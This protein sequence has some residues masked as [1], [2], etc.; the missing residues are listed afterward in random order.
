[1]IPASKD[2]HF[3]ILSCLFGIDPKPT[4]LQKLK[5]ARSNEGLYKKIFP[6]LNVLFF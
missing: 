1:M 4:Q 3:L 6:F 5:E 2:A